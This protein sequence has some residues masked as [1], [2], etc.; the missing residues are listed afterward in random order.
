MSEAK[1][2]VVLIEVSILVVRAHTLCIL[3]SPVPRQLPD[4]DPIRTPLG[5]RLVPPTIAEVLVQ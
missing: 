1:H 3:V 5:Y 2:K 4:D